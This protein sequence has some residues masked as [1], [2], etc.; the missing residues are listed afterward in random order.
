MK[1]PEPE[2]KM[3]GMEFNTLIKVISFFTI[4]SLLAV[5][6]IADGWEMQKLIL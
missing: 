2:L 1:K 5:Y 3:F 4:T 6:L